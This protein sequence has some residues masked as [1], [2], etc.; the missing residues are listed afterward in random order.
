M[1]MTWLIKTSLIAYLEGLPDLVVHLEGVERGQEGFVFTAAEE[2]SGA[3]DA[4]LAQFAG[5]VRFTGHGGMLDLTFAAPALIRRG[6]A[7]AVTIED[8]YEPG[9]LELAT[10]AAF[11]REA[12][13]LR[14]S[15]LA[16]T[17]AGSDLFFGPYT[18][19]TPFDDLLIDDAPEPVALALIGSAQPGPHG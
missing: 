17:E 18:A 14:G 19:G 4:A 3:D 7:R 13:R 2:P 16:L 6:A 12:G 11:T 8:P 10:V 9:R 15:G 1:R 5:A